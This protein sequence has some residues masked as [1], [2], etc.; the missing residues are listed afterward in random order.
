MPNLR[1]PVSSVPVGRGDATGC[2]LGGSPG[3]SERFGR[4]ATAPLLAPESLTAGLPTRPR[5]SQ[6]W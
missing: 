5:P 1:E 6:K 2:L 4:T 3:E